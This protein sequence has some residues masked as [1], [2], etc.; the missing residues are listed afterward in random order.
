MTNSIQIPRQLLW[1]RLTKG[2]LQK[3]TINSILNNR[4][5][6][7]ATDFQYI[8][9]VCF[10]FLFIIMLPIMILSGLFPKIE[11]Y[12][13]IIFYL[14][15]TFMSFIIVNKDCR[16]GRS[17][18]KIIYGYQVVDNSTE[19]PATDFQCMLRNIT[20]LIWPIEVIFLFMSPER[21]IG[22]YIAKTK[23]IKADKQDVTTFINDISRN[24]KLSSKTIIVSVIISSTMTVIALILE[25]I[26]MYKGNR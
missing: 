16:N 21:R 11:S 15:F 1:N 2:L 14:A 17:I 13:S 19:S 18:A 23:V 8:L 7:M 25:F 22:D 10:P 5:G 24:A 9:A 3:S 4:L 6:S 12:L 26:E 20:M